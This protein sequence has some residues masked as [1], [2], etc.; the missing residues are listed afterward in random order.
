VWLAVGEA[1]RA[2]TELTS[3]LADQDEDG[4]VP[5]VRYVGATNPH[6]AF[7]GRPTTSSITQP[8]MYG[9]AVATLIEAGVDVPAEL[10]DR[11]RA[12]IEFLLRRRHPSGLVTVVHPWETGCDDSP[13]FDHWGAE[14]ADRWFAVKGALLATVERSPTGA[15]LANPAFDCA[16][17]GFNALVAWNAGRLGIDASD[18]VDALA[19]QWDGA[20]WVD[21]G[22]ASE[23]SG[24]CRTLDGLLP[25]LLDDRH[26]AVLADLGWTGAFGPRGVHRDEP[27]YEPARY[28]RG[29]VWAPLAFLLNPGGGWRAG[30]VASGWAEWWDADD[31]APGG[32]VP[33]SWST[34]AVV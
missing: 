1:D 33:Q 23:T 3:A 26:Q 16:S 17:A 12:G 31:A 7:W 14:D 18:I 30:A 10:V 15:P 4:F 11:A 6:A 2:V 21:A 28:W 22:A 9:H 20:T 24:R 25:L 29:G 5:H 19:A 32:A 8:P 27:A 13:R 34:L